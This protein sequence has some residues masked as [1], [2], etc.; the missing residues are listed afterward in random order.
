MDKV[1]KVEERKPVSLRYFDL[2]CSCKILKLVEK[3]IL[4]LF[5]SMDIWESLHDQDQLQSR[6]VF[7]KAY[8]GIWMLPYPHDT[9]KSNSPPHSW[10][11]SLHSKRNNNKDTLVN[12]ERKEPILELRLGISNKKSSYTISVYYFKHSCLH[13]RSTALLHQNDEQNH[14][15]T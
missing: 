9:L 10:N 7:Q 6:G 4:E 12:V 13:A 15:R 3:K 11:D 2:S 14:E 5:W 1:S 8:S